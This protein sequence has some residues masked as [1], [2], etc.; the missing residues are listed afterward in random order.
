VG[1]DT[2]ELDDGTGFKEAVSITFDLDVLFL[3]L[4]VSKF[5]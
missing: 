5:G 4:S 3:G 1:D 2:D